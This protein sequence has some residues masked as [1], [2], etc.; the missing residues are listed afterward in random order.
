[1]NWSLFFIYIWVLNKFSTNNS[2]DDTAPI[3]LS[4]LHIIVDEN[5]DG[6]FS[7]YHVSDI[8][9]LIIS[10][11]SDCFPFTSDLRVHQAVRRD[12]FEGKHQV[13]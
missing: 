2:T 1:M 5:G 13:D 11:W 10:Y 8:K 4:S 12:S 7:S 9:Y 3:E 6:R